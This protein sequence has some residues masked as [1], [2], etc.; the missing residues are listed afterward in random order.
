MKLEE[1]QYVSLTAGRPDCNM[2]DEKWQQR[3]AVMRLMTKQTK[4]K[5][6]SVAKANLISG[7]KDSDEFAYHGE[8]LYSTYCSFINGVLSTIRGNGAESPK[9]DYC[10]YIYQITDLLKFEHDRLRTKYLPEYECFEVWL[11]T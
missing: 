9:H 3:F 11:D 6:M 2:T 4:L 10:Y 8:T 1:L 7:H 5:R